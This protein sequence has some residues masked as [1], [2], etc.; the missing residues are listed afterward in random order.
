[1]LLYKKMYEENIKANSKYYLHEKILY[2]PDV[3]HTDTNFINDNLRSFT[4]KIL[5]TQ[6]ILGGSILLFLTKFNMGKEFKKNLAVSV[7]V[8][9]LLPL[10]TMLV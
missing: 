4:Y 3:T 5:M 8:I 10:S 7:P 6:V 1:M 9:G 2:H